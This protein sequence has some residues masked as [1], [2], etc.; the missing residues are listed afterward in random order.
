M[1]I[2]IKDANIVRYREI[3]L[4][5]MK[6]MLIIKQFVIRHALQE[7]IT[8]QENAMIAT[9]FAKLAQDLN[10]LIALSAIRV[11]H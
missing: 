2:A 7:V 9:R 6:A 1:S 8:I 10:H 5:V 4:L 11:L 3:A